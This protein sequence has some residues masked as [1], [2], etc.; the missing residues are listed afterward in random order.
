MPSGQ[1]LSSNTQ[2]E[3]IP[4]CSSSSQILLKHVSREQSLHESG[5]SRILHTGFVRHNGPGASQSSGHKPKCSDI[6]HTSLLQLAI[7]Q[8]RAQEVGFSSTSQTKF[9]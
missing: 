9:P 8:S 5:L 4:W 2:S 7:E 6:S 1:S 3:Q